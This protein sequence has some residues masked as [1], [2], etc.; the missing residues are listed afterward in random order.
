MSESQSMDTSAPG[1]PAIG[2]SVPGRYGLTTGNGVTLQDLHVA[3]AWNLQGD[4]SDMDFAEQV[5]RVF[6]VQRLPDVHGIQSTDRWSVLWLGPTSWLLMF[7]MSEVTLPDSSGTGDA[8]ESQVGAVV[9]SAAQSSKAARTEAAS[10][11]VTSSDP[12]SRGKTVSRAHAVRDFAASRDAI[13][14]AGGAL[15]DVSASRIGW[16]LAGPR[17]A[18]VLNSSC[19]LDLH[20]RAF[21]VGSCAQSLFGHVAA[22]LYRQGSAEF[23]IFVARSLAFDVWQTLCAASAEHGYEVLAPVPFR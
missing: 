19:P 4:G 8:S 10:A 23:S 9:P 16:K 18:T 21:P 7:R 14:A 2:A 11:G 17:A 12:A 20:E 3:A 22:L 15:F 1:F 6:R 5:R 13:N